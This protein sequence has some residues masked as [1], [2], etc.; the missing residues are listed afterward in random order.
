MKI[1][2]LQKL[3]KE[4]LFFYTPPLSQASKPQT[5]WLLQPGGPKLHFLRRGDAHDQ[6]TVRRALPAVQS[7]HAPGQPRYGRRTRQ[8]KHPRF[9]RPHIS[10][11]HPTRV[12]HTA[13]KLEPVSAVIR[14]P[15]HKLIINKVPNTVIF[16]ERP[17]IWRIRYLSSFLVHDFAVKVLIAEVREI[18]GTDALLPT[19]KSSRPFLCSLFSDGPRIIVASIA[20]SQYPPFLQ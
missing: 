3:K 8:H 11:A 15:A 20:S 6:S 17:R 18:S 9:S 2:Q 4:T 19:T 13:D 10:N 5:T 1:A 14:H 12:R 7:P 16:F